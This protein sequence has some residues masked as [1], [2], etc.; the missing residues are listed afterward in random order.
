MS[1]S[2]RLAEKSTDTNNLLVVQSPEDGKNKQIDASEPVMK[3]MESRAAESAAEAS[4]SRDGKI[5]LI[6]SPVLFR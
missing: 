3:M 4:R 1:L 2:H 5:R 6:S